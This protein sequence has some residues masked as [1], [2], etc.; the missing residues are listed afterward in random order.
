VTSPVSWV[1]RQPLAVAGAVT[2]VA[3]IAVALAGPGIVPYDPIKMNPAEALSP[4]TAAHPLGTDQYGRDMLSRAIIGARLSLVTGFGAVSLALV[5]GTIV[6]LLSGLFGGWGDLIIMR[7]VDVMLA[8]P[9][10]LLALVVVAII[11]QGVFNVTVAVGVS[12]VPTFV[13]LVRANVLAVMEHPYIESA[14]AVGCPQLRIATYHV[15]P[16]ILVPLSVLATVAVAWSIIAGSSLSFLG[17]GPRLPTPEWGVDL[18]NGRTLLLRAW[19]VSSAPGACIMLT[20]VAIN[21]VGDALRDLLDPRL[22]RLL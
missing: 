1:R 10:I 16:N 6:G 19:W 2:V 20:V 11:G 4:P 15:V 13:R 14:R 8:F 9:S 21:L 17:L 7:V 5:A 3:I 12:L 18:S 22:R